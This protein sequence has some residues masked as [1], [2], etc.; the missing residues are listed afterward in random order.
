MRAPSTRGDRC[1]RHEPPAADPARR[2]GAS[3]A[4][5]HTTRATR[6]GD[7]PQDRSHP[8]TGGTRRTRTSC[9]FTGFGEVH[10]P[11]CTRRHRERVKIHTPGIQISSRSP[12]Q[13]QGGASSATPSDCT[14]GVP[15]RQTALLGVPPEAARRVGVRLTSGRDR[16]PSRLVRRAT[17]VRH[18]RSFSTSSASCGCQLRGFAVDRTRARSACDDEHAHRIRSVL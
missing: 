10:T 16:H 4:H 9:S 3:R 14:H 8:A 1:H 12:D 5:E 13:S 2:D 18:R 11:A 17:R 15:I 7:W 6:R